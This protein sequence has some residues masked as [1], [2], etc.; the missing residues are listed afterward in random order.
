MQNLFAKQEFERSKNRRELL[1]VVPIIKTQVKALKYTRRSLKIGKDEFALE[2][3]I[4]QVRGKD[5][6]NLL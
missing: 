2:K 3:I 1:I 5:R 4:S 6:I